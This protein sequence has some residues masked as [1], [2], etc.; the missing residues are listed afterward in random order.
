MLPPCLPV[1]A[2]H[3]TSIRDSGSLPQQLSVVALHDGSPMVSIEESD[4][5]VVKYPPDN[6]PPHIFRDKNSVIGRGAVLPI[7]KGEF[8]VPE[9]LAL[10]NAG[11]GLSS[12]IAK[13]MRVVALRVNDVTAVAGFVVPGYRER[14]WMYF[15]Q[16]IRSARVNPRR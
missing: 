5:K 4:L 16:G 1:A 8:V 15:T 9:K 13:G 12:L 10:E 2:S 6:L 14:A 7:G 3:L 11:A